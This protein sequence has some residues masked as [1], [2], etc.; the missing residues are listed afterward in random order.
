MGSVIGPT[1]RGW[2]QR[3]AV[4][5]VEAKL[6]G[7]AYRVAAIRGFFLDY[8]APWIY[9]NLAILWPNLA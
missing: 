7:Y 9:P 6:V 2:A 5:T 8:L 1:E 4:Q 3:T